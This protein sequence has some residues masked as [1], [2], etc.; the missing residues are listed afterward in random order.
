ME[1]EIFWP[2]AIVVA[3]EETDSRS[4]VFARDSGLLVTPPQRWLSA[5]PRVPITLMQE[6]L[7]PFNPRIR[8][9][10]RHATI[11]MVVAHWR[12]VKP[13]AFRPLINASQYRR[14]SEFEASR[15]RLG[16]HIERGFLQRTSAGIS[17]S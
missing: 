10:F 13:E 3:F 14:R 9:T 4:D 7:F 5:S 11:V 2:R 15:R 6:M 1:R 8:G 16:V 12:P 17:H